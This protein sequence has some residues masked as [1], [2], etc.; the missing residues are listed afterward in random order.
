MI[1]PNPFSLEI[2]FCNAILIYTTVI[3]T[4]AI[5]SNIKDTSVVDLWFT[6]MQVESKIR[7]L[8]DGLSRGGGSL[9]AP[10]ACSPRIR[11]FSFS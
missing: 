11:Y 3:V 4:V 8:V 7:N 1:A 9:I 6:V 2:R 10:N 5:V